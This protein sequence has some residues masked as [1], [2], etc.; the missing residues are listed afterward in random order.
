VENAAP[1]DGDG[2]NDGIA[3]RVQSRVTSLK[4]YDNAITLYFVDADRG[5]DTLT[6]DGMVIDL[7]GP[8]FDSADDP[9]STRYGL[10]DGGYFLGDL[11]QV[12]AP[13]SSWSKISATAFAMLL[14]LF[15]LVRLNP[16]K[17]IIAILGRFT[18]SINMTV[19]SSV[20][21]GLLR[22]SI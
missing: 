8:L 13:T 10:G 1:S 5:D 18:L 7:G 21:F 4:T 19:D 9:D 2:N 11:A 12:S 3:D 17:R 16:I 15:I 14:F 20:R 6:Q 22:L